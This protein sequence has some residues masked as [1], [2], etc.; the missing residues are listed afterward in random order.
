MGAGRS[1]RPPAAPEPGHGNGLP[2]KATGY[3]HGFNRTRA[4]RIYGRPVP[5]MT[6]ARQTRKCLSSM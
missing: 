3:S 6:R 1:A 4:A 5:P 2:G